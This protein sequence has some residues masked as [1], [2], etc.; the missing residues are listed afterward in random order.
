MSNSRD[1]AENIKI[2]GKAKWRDLDKNCKKDISL[3]DKFNCG[4]LTDFLNV[5]FLLNDRDGKI[6]M[7]GDGYCVAPRSGC[8]QEITAKIESNDTSQVF[9][10]LIQSGVI[11]PVISGVLM[12]SLLSS[13]EKPSHTFQHAI[14]FAVK[15]SQILINGEPLL[16]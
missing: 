1:F 10:T 3:L 6:R 11:N 13:N 14:N 15:G 7:F 2:V 8:L 4:R 16:K 5:D 9:T 12:G